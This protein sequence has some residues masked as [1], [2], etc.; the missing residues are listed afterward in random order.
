MN[1]ILCSSSLHCSSGIKHRYSCAKI[2]PVCDQPGLGQVRLAPVEAKKKLMSYFQPSSSRPQTT[3]NLDL[4]SLGTL[5]TPET[6]E[7]EAMAS[8]VEGHTKVSEAK[9]KKEVRSLFWKSLLR[10]P[11]PT[12]LCGGHREPCVMRTVKKP[13]PNL[14][15][16]FYMCARPQGPPTD[17]SSRCNFFLWSRPS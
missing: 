8:V 7:E 13:G 12:P 11:L 10:G 1:K 15:R 4:P 3:S 6:S 14:G 9:D 17:P 16:H 2:K 5:V